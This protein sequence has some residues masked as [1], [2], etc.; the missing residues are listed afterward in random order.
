MCWVAVA[1]PQAT[2]TRWKDPNTVIPY[3]V[4]TGYT[5]SGYTSIPTRHPNPWGRLSPSLAD[6]HFTIA[7][8]DWII[9]EIAHYGVKAPTLGDKYSL[10]RSLLSKWLPRYRKNG[11][12]CL[13]GRRGIFFSLII[14]P[15]PLCHK[16]YVILLFSQE[17]FHFLWCPGS[18]IRLS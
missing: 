10:G 4:Y 18:R 17:L 12:V 3:T 13:K 7:E 15:K 1:C 8:K 16:P 14:S 11:K 6:H 9:H 5:V 2:G